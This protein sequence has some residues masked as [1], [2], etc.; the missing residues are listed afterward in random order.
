MHDKWACIH[1]LV[2]LSKNVSPHWIWDSTK[3]CV[4]RELVPHTLN[5]IISVVR[6]IGLASRNL[7]SLLFWGWKIWMNVKTFIQIPSAS[8]ALQLSSF[9]FSPPPPPPAESPDHR[10]RLPSPRIPSPS[11]SPFAP[12][13]S[14]RFTAYNL[15]IDP[16]IH[17]L[18]MVAHL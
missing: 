8:F 18:A 2:S 15:R 9:S 7:T 14:L 5:G 16:S 13:K 11:P 12:Q 6:G 17:Q 10:H 1:D 3:E 4:F